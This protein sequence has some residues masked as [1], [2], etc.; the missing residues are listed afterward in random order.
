VPLQSRHEL[1][2]SLNT[3]FVRLNGCVFVGHVVDPADP[4]RRFSVEL[5]IDGLVVQTAYA[6]RFSTMVSPLV[7]DGCNSFVIQV[8]AYLLESA[9]TAE[10]RIAN[11]GDPIGV[12]IDLADPSTTS[13]AAI[14]ASRLRW[15]GGLRF[16]GWIAET[17]PSTLLK[18]VV[19]G[20]DVMEL[21]N[22]PW[23]QADEEAYLD[24]PVRGIDFH[25]PERF[26]DGCVKMLTVVKGN[27]EPLA[28]LPLPFVAF[29]DGLAATVAGFG[30]LESERLRAELYDHLIPSSLPF[31]SYRDWKERF[32]IAAGDPSDLRAGVV[33]I[34]SDQLQLTIE[35]L[36][37]QTLPRWTAGAIGGG[38]DASAFSAADA[39]SFLDEEAAD[40]DFIVFALAGTEF[41][42]NALG[43]IAA[44]FAADPQ[45][46]AVYGDLEVIAADGSLWPLAFPAFDYERLLEQGYCALVFAL[47]RQTAARQLAGSPSNL[48]RLFNAIFDHSA[49]SQ[50]E[51][52][53]HLP[54][55]IAVL[56]SLDR[57]AAS[58]ALRDATAA[59]LGAR[60]VA[61]AVTIASSALLPAAQVRRTPPH[62]RTTIIIPTR[63]RFEL[64]ANCLESLQPVLARSD[65]DLIV[66]DNDSSDDAAIRFLSQLKD[67]RRARVLPV[68]GPFNYARLNNL[69]ARETGSDFLLL[70]NNDVKALDSTWLDEMHARMAEPDVGAVGALLAWPS[71]MV[72]H[73]G[74]VLGP[75]FAAT[76]AF[77]D[78]T[79]AD[80]GYTDLLRVAHECSAV[81]AACMLTRRDDFLSL[82]G[83]DEIHFPVSFNDVDYCL[84]LRAAS[85]RIIMTPH[86][87]LIHLESASR[88]RL[89]S[90][91]HSARF[92]R[93]LRALRHRWGEVLLRDPFYSPTLSLDPIPFS[94]LAWPVR[95]LSMRTQSPIK[96]ND[97]PAGF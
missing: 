87:R 85:R 91:D 53:A 63:N 77:N 42:P 90:A 67:M 59:H 94:A 4:Y 66:V 5:L 40:C 96:A 48:F 20:E 78:R 30:K 60:Q 46:E 93:E 2:S 25:L 69:A 65:V 41:A 11:L 45:V 70:L 9:G 86:A 88:G 43:R 80:P 71:G 17:E 44:C 24:R 21:G 55:A 64:L 31:T 92:A 56:R 57:E 50:H 72:Q 6:D 84:R 54:G 15:L 22:L 83:M 1:C 51:R 26:A 23:A 62:G 27:G 37:R 58:A 18:I 68:P 32:P 74:V 7:G 36:E 81:T 38:R 12:P 49:A 29:P 47:R 73:G 28:G 76:H 61:A 79:T 34:A 14:A 52:V 95:S 82:G 97:V 3:S 16:R 10:A 13:D 39:K 89:T 75:G 8:G 19:N 33:V 35:S